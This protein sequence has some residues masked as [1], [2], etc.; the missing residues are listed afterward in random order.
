MNKKSHL[1]LNASI[2][3]LNTSIF[4]VVEYDENHH[5]PINVYVISKYDEINNTL[6]TDFSLFKNLYKK[7]FI[8]EDPFDKLQEIKKRMEVLNYKGY[9]TSEVEIDGY[10]ISKYLKKEKN[11]DIDY[12]EVDLKELEI[13][14]RDCFYK[15]YLKENEL[16]KNNNNLFSKIFLEDLLLNR[17]KILSTEKFNVEKKEKINKIN[18]KE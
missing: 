5:A 7:K 12:L 2:L 3:G 6:E 10:E 17:K 1:L 11:I 13:F 14:I 18:K 9:K 15:D 4:C 8:S 16:R